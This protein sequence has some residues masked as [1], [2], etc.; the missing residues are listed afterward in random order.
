MCRINTD[1]SSNNIHNRIGIYE[2]DI[3]YKN[4]LFQTSPNNFHINPPQTLKIRLLQ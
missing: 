3:D 4:F 2:N 1:P